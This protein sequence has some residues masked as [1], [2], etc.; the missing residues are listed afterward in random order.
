MIARC[1]IRRDKF[2][3]GLDRGG[4]CDVFPGRSEFDLFAFRVDAPSRWAFSLCNR[5]ELDTILAV[6]AEGA[7]DAANP[8]QGIVAFNDDHCADQSR[9]TVTLEAGSYWLL[10]AEKTGDASG[11]YA[12]KTEAEEGAQGSDC[13]ALVPASP[14]ALVPQA[15]PSPVVTSTPM[16]VSTSALS[17]TPPVT[18]SPTS[19]VGGSFGESA[20]P[21][22]P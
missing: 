6:Y 2:E 18:P 13:P 8:C 4:M 11:P 16:P 17:P 9:L 21:F 19:A 22:A 7:F 12:F 10:I 3:R 14:M 20:I 1:E 15:L 5:T